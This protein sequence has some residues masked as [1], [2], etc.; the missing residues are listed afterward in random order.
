VKKFIICFLALFMSVAFIHAA[1]NVAIMI[2]VK[3]RECTQIV[4]FTNPTN[5][6]AGMTGGSGGGISNVAVNGKTGVLSGSGSN[7]LSTVTLVPSDL[8]AVDTNDANY[9]AAITNIVI[10]ESTS[11]AVQFTHFGRVAAISINTNFE[12]AVNDATGRVAGVGYLLPPSTQDLV[13]VSQLNAATSSNTLQQVVNRSS[14][15]VTNADY[16]V[17]TNATD[18]MFAGWRFYSAM[19]GY[20]IHPYGE[21]HLVDSGGVGVMDFNPTLRNL[22]STNSLVVAAFADVF[23]VGPDD[24]TNIAVYATLT[25]LNTQ[26]ATKLA[27][28]DPVYLAAVTNGGATINGSPITNGATFTITGGGG[29]GGISNVVVN[30]QAGVLSG[31][32]SNV[33]STVTLSADDVGAISATEATNIAIAV[34]G[35]A[36]NA[37]VIAATNLVAGMGFLTVESDPTFGAWRT[38]AAAGTTN[39]ILPNGSLI[40]ISTLLGIA[41]PQG[42]AGTNGL[43]GTNGA[44]G[45]TGPAGTNGID[46]TVLAD[47]TYWVTNT[48]PFTNTIDFLISGFAANKITLHD[49]RMFLSITN[50]SPISKRATVGM[51]RNSNRR[52]DALTYLDTNQLYYSVLTTVAGV[53]GESS[54]VVADASGSVVNDLYYKAVYGTETNDYQRV[55]SASATAIIWQ[56][57]NQFSSGIGTL[58]SHVNQ[59]GGFPYYDANGSSTMWFR[60]TFGTGYTGT[61]Q[62]VINYGR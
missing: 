29:G 14:G 32:G 12:A 62:T 37:A 45:A 34:V 49:V 43:N 30:G 51:F 15:P 18:V 22:L 20:R 33:L 26:I 39:A 21:G 50:G 55:Q 23:T 25:N 35:P 57:T 24:G 7:V 58:I 53:A 4:K 1:T 40:D 9:K 36:T 3:T 56:C 8:G 13:T 46:G 31:S 47:T 42:P 59:F 54:N 38:N 28:N 5:T 17:Q 60:L 48:T 6:Y 16:L 11:N 41:G 2:D 19:G 44:P 10:V 27:T 61:V 52:C